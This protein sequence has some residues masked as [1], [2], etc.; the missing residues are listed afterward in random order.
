M[1]SVAVYRCLFDDYDYFLKDLY[2]SS[3]IDYYLFTDDQNIN[4]HNYKKILKGKTEKN[5]SLDNRN[6]KLIVPNELLN[7]DVTIYLDTNIN[8]VGDISSLIE[9]F[10]SSEAEIGLFQHPYHNFLSDDVDMCIASEKSN[11]EVMNNE[12]AYYENEGLIPREGFSDNS[13]IFRKQQNENML[14]AMKYWMNLLK[15]YS[16]RDQISLPIVR[17]KFNL[18]EH[19]FNFSPRTKNNDYFVV[20]PH[21]YKN[22]KINLLKFYKFTIKFIHRLLLRHYIFIKNKLKQ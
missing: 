11:I 13:I 22:K 20:F 14:H 10:L 19:F 21:K 6:I 8:I 15:L 17:S 5:S 3:N 7:Y 18:N 9:N 16:G 4:S 2:V 1:N 12:L